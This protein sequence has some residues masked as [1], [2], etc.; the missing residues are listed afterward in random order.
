MGHLIIQ[1]NY[2]KPNM[3]AGILININYTYVV[4]TIYLLQVGVPILP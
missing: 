3:S 1:T 4:I 2:I